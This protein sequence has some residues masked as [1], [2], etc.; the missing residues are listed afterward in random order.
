MLTISQLADY[1]GVTVR[2][3]RHYHQCGLLA[4]PER[5]ASG[6]RRYGA[7]AVVDLVRIK[8]LADAG[9]PLARIEQLHRAGPEQFAEAVAEIDQALARKIRELTDHRRRIAEL[10]AGER[11]FLPTEM[12]DY[13]DELRSVGVS[14]RTVQLE[15]DG[16]IMLTISY[17]EDALQ[18]LVHKRE[19]LA[20]PA[21]RRL[22]L[23]FDQAVDWAPDDPRLEELADRMIAFFTLKH[24]EED[25]PMLADLT[26]Q[27]PPLRS[28]LE[29]HLENY[30]PAWEKLNL[31][32]MKRLAAS[33]HGAAADQ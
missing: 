14:A 25:P 23:T 28:M 8:T 24:Q 32:T 3:V 29:S 26:A 10:V 12:V 31:L 5:D 27:S 7:Q 9:V 33:K 18:W 16:W 20:D 6:Y 19:G 11:L 30:S 15:R 17:P 2:A 13:L 1:V 22:Y 4:E 21:F